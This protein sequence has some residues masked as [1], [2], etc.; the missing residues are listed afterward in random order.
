M[1]LGAMFNN[2]YEDSLEIRVLSATPLGL[3]TLLYEGAIAA[4]RAA[5]NHLSKGDI[6]PRSRAVT[7]AVNILIELENSLNHSADR[8]LC[9]RLSGLYAFMRQTLLE[10]NYHQTEAG[11]ITVEELLVSLGES[12]V[13]IG[14]Q[15]WIPEYQIPVSVPTQT[16]HWSA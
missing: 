12:W 4:V 14:T 7:K 6:R 1:E 13:Q 3:V 8:E 9:A 2:P 11:L 10:A 15:P 16:R 5:R